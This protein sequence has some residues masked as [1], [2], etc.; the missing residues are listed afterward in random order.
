MVLVG[1]G[2]GAYGAFRED[3]LY[4][5]LYLAIPLYTAYY[6]VTRWDDLWTWFACSTLGVGLVLLTSFRFGTG[7]RVR[8]RRLS[9]PLLGA[10]SCCGLLCD[11]ALLAGV[12]DCRL[13]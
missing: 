4:G 10:L 13:G 6:I 3:V 7:Q 2:A 9:A 12:G 11:A 8:L 1:F 5:F